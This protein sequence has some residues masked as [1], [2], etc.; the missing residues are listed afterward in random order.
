MSIVY[1]GLGTNLGNKEVNLRQAINL[2]RDFP[3]T[4]VSKT[5]KVYET[6]PW[7]YSQQDDFLNLCLEIE[8]KL[9]PK[10]LLKKCQLVEEKLGRKRLV[11]WGPRSIDVDI[12]IYDELTLEEEELTI[13]HPRIGERAFVLVPLSE[14]N[15]NL[16]I[17]NQN[18]SEL[19]KKVATDGIKEYELEII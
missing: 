12:L 15:N 5:S 16:I 4:S 11:K 9:K 18:I 7:G 14:L 2:I 17:D 13:P 1:L 19:I 8:T 6:E 10:E 3:K